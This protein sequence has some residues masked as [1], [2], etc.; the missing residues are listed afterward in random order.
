VKRIAALILLAFASLLSAQN[1][2]PISN[3]VIVDQGGQPVPFA[4]VRICSVTSTGNPCT[5][6]VPI[7][8]DA[9]LSIPTGN[10]IQADQYGNYTVYGGVLAFPNMYL[11][12]IIPAS[13]VTYSYVVN[14]PSCSLAGCTLTGPITATFFNA[15]TPPY[16]EINGTQVD[17]TMLLDCANLAKLNAANVFTG[18]PQ[19]APIFNATTQFNVNG[20]QIAAANLADGTTGTGPIV[21][22]TSPN[23]ITPNIGA[24]SGTTLTLTGALNAQS[25]AFSGNV[26]GAVLNAN[27]G[28]TI[29]G[30]AP[31]NHLLVGNG[32]TYADSATLPS[33]SLPPIYF[34]T[35]INGSHS[36][37]SPSQD[38]YL[39]VGTGTGM[40]GT[41][42]IGVGGTVART[43]LSVNATNGSSGLNFDPFVVITSAAGT[44]GN[45]MQWDSVGGAGDAGAACGSA[46]SGSLADPGYYVSP[47][48]L[49]FEWGSTTPGTTSNTLVGIPHTFPH[50][51]F[52]AFVTTSSGGGGGQLYDSAGAVCTST[53]QITVAASNS[54]LTLSFFVIGW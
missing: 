10:P 22:Q 6:T 26:S 16:Y 33:G 28:Y 52:R 39:A 27:T 45:C 13:G 17:C 54:S 8:L 49:I 3:G 38:S 43:V 53:S 23:L 42:V 36:T 32:T 44:S 5:P 50:A 7:Y 15:T 41:H 47:F 21:L 14:G 18:S 20:S 2:V 37:D 31:L 12:Q 9:G 19:T 34:Q 11:V 1:S 30:L 25:G 40:V 46:G 48:G 4:T 29:G 51:C 35:V 24:A